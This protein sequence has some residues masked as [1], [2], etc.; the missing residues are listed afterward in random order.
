MA[1]NPPQALKR[2][3]SHSDIL[4]DGVRDK[5]RNF[6]YYAFKTNPILGVGLG[7]FGKLNLADIEKEVINDYNVFDTSKYLPSAHAH[8]VYYTYLVSGGVLIFAIFTWFW[9]YIA[10]VLFKLRTTMENRWVFVSAA[11]VMMV[12]L[13]V[14]W[15]NTTLHHEHAILSMFVLGI[16]ISQYRKRDENIN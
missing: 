6:S 11:S 13:G 14:G 4:N 1:Y 2:I 12:N 16:L 8:N 7:N 10:F 3:Q 5:I 9:F 15:V